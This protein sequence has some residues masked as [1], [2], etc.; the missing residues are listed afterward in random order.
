MTK[1]APSICIKAQSNHNALFLILL[2]SILFML[3]LVLSQHYW[4][5]FHLVLTF[6]YL[7]ELVVFITGLAK[8]FQPQFSLT[9]T[10]S[11]LK[12]QHRYGQWQLSWQ[13]IQRISLMNETLGVNPLQL[14]FIGIRLTAIATLATSISPRL[15][16]RLIHEQ[17]PLLAMA[18]RLRLITL[19]QSQLNFSPFILANG[20]II[21]GPLAAF[22][23]HSSILHNALGY[24]LFIPE[25]AL[26]RQLNEFC[27]LLNQCKQSARHYIYPN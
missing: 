20:E 26:D 1:N 5:Q 16:N 21:K 24:H 7:A 27:V 9:L 13:D 12:Y 25:S 4:R 22:L 6:I 19:E 11:Y 23:H 3:T 2:A 18:I 8:Y 15:A 10:P 14:P 17:R